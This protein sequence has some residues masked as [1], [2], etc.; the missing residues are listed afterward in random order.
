[1]YG[2]GLYE[3]K[4]PR[5]IINR[6]SSTA[7]LL[8]DSGD[9]FDPTNNAAQN[10]LQAYNNFVI[11]KNQ[12]LLQG[13]F[14][15]VQLTEVRFP[16]AI[17]NITPFNNRVTFAID[18]SAAIVNVAQGFYTGVQLA[19]QLQTEIRGNTFLPASRATIC[20][21]YNDISGG[22]PVAPNTAFESGGFQFYNSDAGATNALSISSAPRISGNYTGD[23]AYGASLLWTL[24]FPQNTTT[25]V[26]NGYTST[27]KSWNAPL[28]YTQYVDIVSEQLTNFQRVKDLT[29]QNL[30]PRQ[31]VICR[32]YVSDETSQNGP[33]DVKGT[34]PFVIHRQIHTPKAI[35]WSGDS[36]IGQIDIKLYDMW[37]NPLYTPVGGSKIFDNVPYAMPDFQLTFLASED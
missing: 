17:P 4:P 25:T 8:L 30:I 18:A 15:R 29:T 9:R 27:L 26:A 3:V 32:L 2:S 11:T 20:V 22:N 16:W 37:G 5:T 13:A 1:M 23:P 33:L 35:R 34:A 28:L 19:A 10:A 6:P 7:H 36:S 12:N 14:T 31:S 24:G 21:T